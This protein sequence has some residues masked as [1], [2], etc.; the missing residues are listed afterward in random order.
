MWDR[1]LHEGKDEDCQDNGEFA[2]IEVLPF[3]SL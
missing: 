2:F 1:Q 3:Y